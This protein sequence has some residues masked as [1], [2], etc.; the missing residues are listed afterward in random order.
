V[1]PGN[2]V[3]QPQ[4]GR[5]WLG[6][7]V[8]LAIAAAVL[9]ALAR[10]LFGRRGRSG[11]LPAPA[12]VAVQ[13]ATDGFWI[14]SPRLPPGTVLRYRCRVKGTLHE[15]QFTIAPGPTGLFV[16][17]GGTPT[18][19]VILEIRPSQ[20]AQQEDESDSGWLRPTVSR[21]TRLSSGR[22]PPRP[23]SPPPGRSR[24]PAAY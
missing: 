11:R 23:A 14:E 15:A 22:T 20:W 17:T 16:Y 6:V 3:P 4:G 2:V 18:D 1:S 9:L 8:P 7:G 21:P 12:E 19:I 5:N 24:F 10:G 13:P